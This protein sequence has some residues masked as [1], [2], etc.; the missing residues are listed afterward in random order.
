V[1]TSSLR[2]SI[3]AS[4]ASPSASTAWSGHPAAAISAPRWLSFSTP[5]RSPWGHATCHARTAA[6][7]SRYVPPRGAEAVDGAGERVSR[8]SRPRVAG[9]FDGAA[10]E[11]DLRSIEELDRQE[12][13]PAHQLVPPNGVVEVVA[14]LEE[15]PESPVPQPGRGEQLE[16]VAVLP[17]GGQ[18]LGQRVPR[19]R[20]EAGLDA[21]LQDL[22]PSGC[23]RNLDRQTG[24]IAWV[25]TDGR[26][27]RPRG[28]RPANGA[29]PSSATGGRET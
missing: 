10:Q 3:S 18:R 17:P 12:V 2:P 26:A 27:L 5:S 14:R 1:M 24:R 20:S 25:G 21:T 16:G 9:A 7:I 11:R 23:G 13:D 22:L 4:E 6:R 28:L 29:P 15:H 19:G 8:H